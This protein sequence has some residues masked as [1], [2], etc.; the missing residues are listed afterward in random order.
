MTVH[1][2]DDL[3]AATSC[4]TPE[5]FDLL[6][7]RSFDLDPY[8]VEVTPDAVTVGMLDS[9]IGMKFPFTIEQFWNSISEFE[10]QVRRRVEDLAARDDPP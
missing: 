4:R 3:L 7:Y 6:L 8:V 5:E 9:G 1:D 2:F 10:T